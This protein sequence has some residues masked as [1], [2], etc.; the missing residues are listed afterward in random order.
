MSIQILKSI[1]YI[2][3]QEGR[4]SARNA[5][6]PLD[7]WFFIR[8][9]LAS[10]QWDGNYG[11]WSEKK[12]HIHIL[13]KISGRLTDV[14]PRILRSQLR[15]PVLKVLLWFYFIILYIFKIISLNIKYLQNSEVQK[16][17]TVSAVSHRCV[18]ALCPF[19]L[20]QWLVVAVSPFLC[21]LPYILCMSEQMSV[22]IL[23][24]SSLLHR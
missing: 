24:L 6:F 1:F 5:D 11:L 3:N 20:R 9:P 2:A 7:K 17:I 14:S 21:S 4:Q 15:I 22:Y 12:A 23:S 10:W 16:D 13:N 8:C 19:L 18:P